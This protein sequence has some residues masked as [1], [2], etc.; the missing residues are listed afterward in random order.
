MINKPIILLYQ[1]SWFSW[2]KEKQNKF[3]NSETNIHN[4]IS[5]YLAEKVHEDDVNSSSN[6][7]HTK[8]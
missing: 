3:F 5:C 2:S 8:S 1:K 7:K 6:L 4:L